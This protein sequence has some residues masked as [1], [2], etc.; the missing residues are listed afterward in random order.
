[1]TSAK[2]ST[3]ITYEV[4]V[5]KDVIRLSNPQNNVGFYNSPIGVP[6]ILMTQQITNLF[7]IESGLYFGESTGVDMITMSPLDTTNLLFY[8]EEFHIP[9]RI[10]I[11]KSIFN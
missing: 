11:H 9:I 6:G 1:M 4:G 3:F 8:K 2:K 10:R 7:Y 5:T